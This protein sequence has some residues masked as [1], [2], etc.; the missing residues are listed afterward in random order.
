MSYDLLRGLP[1]IA[2]I[3]WLAGW[4]LLPSLYV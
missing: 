2:V 1:Q 4:M 3:A